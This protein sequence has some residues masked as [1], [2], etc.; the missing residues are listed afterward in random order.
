MAKNDAKKKKPMTIMSCADISSNF[1]KYVKTN[2]SKALLKGFRGLLLRERKEEEA[3]NDENGR[4][5]DAIND[6]EKFFSD[7][8]RAMGLSDAIVKV[9]FMRSCGRVER[10]S[11]RFRR[12]RREKSLLLLSLVRL[13]IFVGTLVLTP[14]LC[15]FSLS[16]SFITTTTGAGRPR[17]G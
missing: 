4:G 5:K 14:I 17:G 7:A 6:E 9:G 13:K 12:A 2:D 3:E 11:R 8:K 15:V 16:L 10:A 1:S